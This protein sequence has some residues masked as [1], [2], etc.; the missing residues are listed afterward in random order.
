MNHI[1]E[2][3]LPL[4][5]QGSTECVRLED[6]EIC[7]EQVFENVF[8]EQQNKHLLVTTL[9][10]D[11]EAQIRE[12]LYFPERRLKIVKGNFYLVKSLDAIWQ[13]FREKLF[14]CIHLV[15]DEKE[16]IKPLDLNGLSKDE[17]RR[18]F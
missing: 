5:F 6:Y 1:F 9:E 18:L 11:N 3:L 14:V 13:F 4:V 10:A 8:K 17:V 12:Y 16:L 7:I 15:Y 2:K